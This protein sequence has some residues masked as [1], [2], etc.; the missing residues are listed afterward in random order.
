MR[1]TD[2]CSR[3]ARRLQPETL[4]PINLRAA[5]FTGALRQEI[6]K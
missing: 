2:A 1:M 4:L 3:T 5:R 6:K